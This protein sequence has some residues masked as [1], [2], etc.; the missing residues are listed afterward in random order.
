M[1]TK[2]KFARLYE[3]GRIL[4]LRMLYPRN[5]ADIGSFLI[6]ELPCAICRKQRRTWVMYKSFMELNA[7]VIANEPHTHAANS[8]HTW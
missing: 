6:G 5:D 1:K 2:I 4:Q 3:I 8:W 7:D